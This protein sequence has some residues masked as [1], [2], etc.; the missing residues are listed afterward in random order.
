MLI[1]LLTY[2]PSYQK[3]TTSF[4]ANRAKMRNNLKMEV[5]FY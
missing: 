4:N 1:N 5:V 3:K 2:L